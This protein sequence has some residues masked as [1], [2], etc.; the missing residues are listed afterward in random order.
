M[1]K[2]KA[3]K[4]TKNK[5]WEKVKTVKQIKKNLMEARRKG[6]WIACFYWEIKLDNLLEEGV[7]KGAK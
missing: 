6:W 2:M 5:G 7:R 4:K 3:K 1:P